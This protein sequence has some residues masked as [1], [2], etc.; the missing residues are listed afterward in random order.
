MVMLLTATAS[1]FGF[2]LAY[3][4]V[5]GKVTAALA[6]VSSNK[7]VILLLINVMLL[8]LGCIMDMAPLILIVTPVLLPVVTGPVVGMAP[9]HFGIML[10]LNLGIGLCT[11]PVGSTLFVGCAIGK[12]SIEKMARSLWPFYLA[13]IVIL[14]LVTYVPSVTMWLPSLIMK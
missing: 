11:P 10:M 7:F 9:V 4:G 3:L 12:I 6:A 1:T 13:M 14:L 2:L 5:P 8:V